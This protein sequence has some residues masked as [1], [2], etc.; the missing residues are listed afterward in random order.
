M[1]KMGILLLF[2]ATSHCAQRPKTTLIK[3]TSFTQN[4]LV[5]VHDVFAY[6]A[7]HEQTA[8]KEELLKKCYFCLQHLTSLHKK[9]QEQRASILNA[10]KQTY[11]WMERLDTFVRG[12]DNHSPEPSS[13]TN[14]SPELTA[15]R[16]AIWQET[17]EVRKP[18]VLFTPLSHKAPLQRAH[19]TSPR[20][21]NKRTPSP[22]AEDTTK[23]FL[24]TR[25]KTN[26]S[27]GDIEQHL[28]RA[29]EKHEDEALK[30]R[31]AQIKKRNYLKKEPELLSLRQAVKSDPHPRSI[32]EQ[33]REQYQHCTW[34]MSSECHALFN[35]KEQALLE[36]AAQAQPV[37]ET[38]PISFK[39]MQQILNSFH[40]QMKQ[41][42]NTPSPRSSPRLLS[43]LH[44]SKGK[45]SETSEQKDRALIEELLFLLPS[46]QA[47]ET[48][49]TAEQLEQIKKDITCVYTWITELTH[50]H[51]IQQLVMPTYL[52]EHVA[53]A[54]RIARNAAFYTKEDIANLFDAFKETSRDLL[55]KQKSM[56][57]PTAASSSHTPHKRSGVKK[58][59]TKYLERT[60]IDY[61]HFVDAAWHLLRACPLDE[62]IQVV[63]QLKQ[64]EVDIKH[65]NESFQW[66]SSLQELMQDVQKEMTNQA[67]LDRLHRS[68]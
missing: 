13:L 37:H 43:R 1:Q 7:E 68:R 64:L 62:K 66:D 60:S 3:Q 15:R 52:K 28:H 56:T 11:Q 9:D 58:C 33:Y 44:G 21:S 34:P 36:R 32:L 27:A 29:K 5:V 57:I 46:L 18:Q 48:S 16:N 14:G 35:E 38:C 39:D 8:P 67:Q 65:L 31:L 41:K 26:S 24:A 20:T 61:H 22:L 54:E 42:S 55:R 53:Y 59:Y 2:I 6:L 63:A 10:I 40:S 12:D 47:L 19:S 30:K 51:G 23:K 25:M 17:R 49:A 4:E 45:K 50:T